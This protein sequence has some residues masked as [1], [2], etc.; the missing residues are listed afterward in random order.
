MKALILNSGLGSRMGAHTQQKPKC[1]AQIGGGYT[2]LSRQLTQLAAAGV[3]DIVITT[4]P[5]ANALAAHVAE[6]QLPIQVTYVHCE[7]YATTNY[8]VSMHR[9]APHLRGHDVLLLHGDLVLESSVYAD[10]LQSPRSVMTVDETLPLPQKDFKARLADGRIVE[11]GVSLFGKECV[12]CQPAYRFTAE[13][14]AQWLD[15]IDVFVANGDTR[16]YAEN[17]FNAKNG[18]IPLWPLQLNGRLCS[19]I[20]N[21]EDLAQVSER[22]LRTLM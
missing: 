17:A 19:E 10:L 11:V 8:I 2:I 21:P 12:A 6:L 9:A 3:R 7:D 4:G 20:D 16:V 22:F 15:A 5:F 14:F 13:G 1:M 18:S